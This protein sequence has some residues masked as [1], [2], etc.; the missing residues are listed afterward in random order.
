MSNPSDYTEWEAVDVLV[1]KPH[2]Q[3]R[4][5]PD[6]S[7]AGILTLI[8]KIPPN[9]R[10]PEIQK[11]SGSE[12]LWLITESDG[13]YGLIDDFTIQMNR[14]VMRHPN[15]MV[16]NPLIKQADPTDRNM[17]PINCKFCGKPAYCCFFNRI[18]CSA[19]CKDS[20][21]GMGAY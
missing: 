6:P 11:T 20:Y 7:G 21:H 8:R 2:D 14:A 16:P 12:E 4:P 13:S 18:H 1:L 19:K 10:I 5:D 3:I 9:T 17:W 15:N